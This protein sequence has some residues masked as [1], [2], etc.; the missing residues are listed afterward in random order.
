[1]AL[2]QNVPQAMIDEHVPWHA[3]P[4]NPAAGGR[5]INPWPPTGGG[6]AAGSGEEFLVWHRGFVERFH[7][8]VGGLAANQGPPAESIASWR[9]T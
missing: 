7:Q 3:R 9:V 1:M 6:P 4:G 5:R 8:W 2:I